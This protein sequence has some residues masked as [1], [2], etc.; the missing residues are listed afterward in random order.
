MRSNKNQTHFLF[1]SSDE[2]KMRAFFYNRYSLFEEAISFLQY[3]RFLFELR[4]SMQTTIPPSTSFHQLAFTP[5]LS[6]VSSL[7][8]IHLFSSFSQHQNPS[9]TPSNHTPFSFHPYL[10][11]PIALSSIL[12]IYIRIYV[13][14]YPI[15]LYQCE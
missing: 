14:I 7:I 13:C 12:Y 5:S 3:I 6:L 1:Y 10:S 8:F 2:N 4:S 15:L 11:L 9:Y